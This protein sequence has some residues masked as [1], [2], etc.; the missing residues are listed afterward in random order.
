M[1]RRKVSWGKNISFIAH[2]LFDNPGA[3][4]GEIRRALCS[5]KGVE[6]T[7]PT[8]MRGQYTTY[9]TTGWIGGKA[10]PKNP[11]GRYWTRIPRPDGKNGYMLTLEGIT[12]VNLEKTQ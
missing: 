11:C 8:E 6:W 3:A 4:S 5:H 2:Y 7:N 10:W 1:R 9:F 12:K